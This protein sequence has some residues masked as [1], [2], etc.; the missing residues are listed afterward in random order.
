MLPGYFNGAPRSRRRTPPGFGWKPLPARRNSFTACSHL[1]ESLEFRPARRIRVN[2]NL[3]RAAAHF[4]FHNARQNEGVFVIHR[5]VPLLAFLEDK[6]RG[7]SVEKMQ[8]SRISRKHLER[9]LE[10]NSLLPIANSLSKRSTRL[11]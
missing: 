4:S 10:L 1:E 7:L 3:A 2:L 11:T 5:P 9:D 8:F 6:N